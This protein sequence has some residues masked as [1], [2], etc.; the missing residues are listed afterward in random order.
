MKSG[1][2]WIAVLVAG[3]VVN[4]VDFL[5]QGTLLTK[6][7]YSKM[8]DVIRQDAPVYWFVVGDFIAVLV[9][10]WVY[11]KVWS[12]FGQGTRGGA[13]CG[14]YLGVFASFPLFHF[15]NLMFK[16]Y[17]YGLVW[18]STVYGILWYVLAGTILAVVMKKGV[19]ATAPKAG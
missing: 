5:V 18:V 7:Y 4:L 6:M 12:V 2:F 15:L 11:D 19:D 9:L 3:V 16:G 8:A 10:A 17:P 14:L 1:K 13:T